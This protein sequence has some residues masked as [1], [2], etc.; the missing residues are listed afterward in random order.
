LQKNQHISQPRDWETLAKYANTLIAKIEKN[1]YRKIIKQ[2][3][4]PN[5]SLSHDYL[6]QEGYVYGSISTFV[7]KVIQKVIN[8]FYEIC[9]T[10]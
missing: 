7:L 2:L 6:R 8:K 4:V 10:S 9:W 1:Y 5:K 3:Q